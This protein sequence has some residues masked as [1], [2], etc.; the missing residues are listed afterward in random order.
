MPLIPDKFMIETESGRN[1]RISLSPTT[2]GG[3][4]AVRVVRAVRAV[5]VDSRCE[6]HP[7]LSHT[8]GGGGENGEKA[9]KVVR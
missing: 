5:R 3:V 6:T 2:V 9:S 8:K 4:R 7:G 1:V